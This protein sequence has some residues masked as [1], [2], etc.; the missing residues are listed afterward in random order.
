M[1][2]GTLL[3]AGFGIYRSPR[4]RTALG[5]S[6]PEGAASPGGRKARAVASTVTSRPGYGQLL[7]T[8][9]AW[10]FLLPGFAARQPFAYDGG[11]FGVS[12]GG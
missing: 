4:K 2:A 5:A 10:T 7:R 3:T 12:G 8:S 11:V 9:G 6:P 1:A